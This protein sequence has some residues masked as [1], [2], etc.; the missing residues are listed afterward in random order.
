MP[1]LPLFPLATIAVPGGV[2]PLVIFEDRYR[3]LLAE[4]VDRPADERLFGVMAIRRGHEVGA[5][6]AGQLYDVGTAVRVVGLQVARGAI[7]VG[8][9]GVQR[10]RLDVELAGAAYPLG[11]VTWLPEAA[12]DDAAVP[13]LAARLREAWK[14]YGEV[15]GAPDLPTDEEI[16]A[17]GESGL[18]Y[19]A[20]DRLPLP[21][22]ERQRVLDI[23]TTSERLTELVR[24]LRREA[25]LASGL[26]TRPAP[27]PYG[28]PS[29]N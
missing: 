6:R 17:P 2:L 21:L 14:R 27:L 5:G 24:V 12:G 28:P 15:V 26:G 10:F 18:A 7:R 4:L 29:L 23:A 19:A 22:P 16:G 20:L 1:A 9:V 11:E 8:T 13:A 25:A 3:A